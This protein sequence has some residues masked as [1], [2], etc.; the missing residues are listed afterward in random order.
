M[1]TLARTTRPHRLHWWKEAI[2]VISFY[3]LY[4]WSRNQFGSARLAA[5]G[6]P[7]HAFHNAIRIVRAEKALGLFHEAT[8]QSWFT[9]STAVMQFWNTYYGTAHFAVTIGVFAVLYWKRPDV[10]PIWRNTILFT[11]GLAI[12]GFSMFPLMPPRL[13]DAPCP[14]VTTNASGQEVS[15]YGGAC[16][17]S[18]QR[19]ATPTPSTERVPPGTVECEQ[20]PFR[21][22]D[23]LE[24]Y[25]GPWSFNSNTIKNLSNQYAAMPSLHIGW[26]TWCAFAMWPLLRRR[27]WRAAMLLYPMLTL[28]CI[29]VTANHYWLDG[30]GGLFTLGV[31]FILGWALHIWN[32]NRLDRRYEERH[33]DDEVTASTA[34][35]ADAH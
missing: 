16:I 30:V 35:A 21:F 13:L 23:S 15:N 8:I 10:F 18:S 17:P 12:I 22:I 32:Q 29:I 24:C 27:R 14:E 1:Q 7:E 11:T 5:E 28:T 19:P 4:S 9:G 6:P 25:G 20:G 2:L 26:S 3:L 33:P 31:G 34:L